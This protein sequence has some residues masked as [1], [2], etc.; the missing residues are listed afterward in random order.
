MVDGAWIPIVIFLSI[1]LL[2]GIVLYFRHERIK[3]E[4][5]GGGD[6]RR[7]AEEAVRGQRLVLE[8]TQRMNATLKEIERLLREV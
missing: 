3:V 7:L 2:V 1:P 5:G 4:A 8:E 6:Y